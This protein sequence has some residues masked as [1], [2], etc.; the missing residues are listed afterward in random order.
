MGT[1]PDRSCRT[2]SVQ[3]YD[4]H[5]W[6]CV[7]GQH[8]VVYQYSAEMSCKDAQRE[9]AACGTLTPIEGTLGS[10]VADG[11]TPVPASARWP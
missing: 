1:R 3:G 6:N 9:V 7:D 5:I 2:G 10:Q 11:C 4:V 8:V